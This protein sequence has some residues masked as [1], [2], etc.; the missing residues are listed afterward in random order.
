MDLGRVITLIIHRVISD[1]PKEA[2]FTT[3]VQHI[4]ERSYKGKG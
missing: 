2:S 3:K 1:L 4:P